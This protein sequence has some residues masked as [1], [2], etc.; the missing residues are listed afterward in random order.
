MDKLGI[1]CVIRDPSQYKGG[2]WQE[3]LNADRQWQVNEDM[4]EFFLKYL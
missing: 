1:E 3:N 2:N 4:V